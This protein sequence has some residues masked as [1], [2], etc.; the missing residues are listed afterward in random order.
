MLWVGH[1][2]KAHHGEIGCFPRT[3]QK[4]QR[5]G[6]DKCS[7]GLQDSSPWKAA[8]WGILSLSGAHCPSKR[9]DSTAEPHHKVADKGPDKLSQMLLPWVGLPGDIRRMAV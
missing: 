3:R 8:V 5:G 6:G 2:D 1:V 4:W 7:S 9:A